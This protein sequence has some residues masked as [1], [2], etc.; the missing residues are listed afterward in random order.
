MFIIS[1]KWQVASGKLA[2]TMDSAS[3]KRFVFFLLLVTCNLLL[4]SPARAILTIEI[5]QSYDDGMPIAIVP[6]KS[7]IM[8]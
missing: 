1:S 3:L 8:S 7:K 6:F 5:T 4:A 2:A